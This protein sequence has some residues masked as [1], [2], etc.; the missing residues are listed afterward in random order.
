MRGI[1][2]LERSIRVLELASEGM[3]RVIIKTTAHCESHD[4][5]VETNQTT[6]KARAY[7]SIFDGSAR[8][9]KMQIHKLEPGT[10]KQK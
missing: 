5:A 10:H 8:R 3:R 4:E 7:I 1:H 2:L 6:A 9:T